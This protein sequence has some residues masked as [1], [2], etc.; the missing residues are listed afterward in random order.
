MWQKHSFELGNVVY[1]VTPCIIITMQRMREGKG[2][3]G[4]ERRREERRETKGRRGGKENHG[5]RR[6]SS[7]EANW[8][9]NGFAHKDMKRFPRVEDYV[10]IWGCFLAL[11]KERSPF[12]SRS[13]A[14]WLSKHRIVA[15]SFSYLKALN[16]K[17]EQPD[18]RNYRRKENLSRFYLSIRREN[19][20]L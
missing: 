20:E 3:R 10:N 2:K 13:L 6:I 17:T 16:I 8:S 9:K 19:T 15:F 1:P 7:T 4:E 12:Y 18:I 5:L 11:N 14:N